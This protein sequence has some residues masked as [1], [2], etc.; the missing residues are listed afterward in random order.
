MAR[1]PELPS[2]EFIIRTQQRKLASQGIEVKLPTRLPAEVYRPRFSLSGLL[3]RLIHG[4]SDQDQSYLKD[5]FSH[6][7][8]F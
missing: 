6:P 4:R 1:L 3:H 5:K 8:G 7:G 2:S